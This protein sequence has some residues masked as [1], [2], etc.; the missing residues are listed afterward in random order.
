MNEMAKTANAILAMTPIVMIEA[1]H[2][3]HSLS[4][5]LLPVTRSAVRCT[6]SAHCEAQGLRVG[7]AS[8]LQRNDSTTGCGQHQD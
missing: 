2:P 7:R 6:H 4:V 1:G 3:T 5:F 8:R